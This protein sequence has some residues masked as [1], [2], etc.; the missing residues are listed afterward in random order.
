MPKE[1][2]IISKLFDIL[3][4]DFKLYLP[5]SLENSHFVPTFIDLLPLFSL[6]FKHGVAQSRIHQPHLWLL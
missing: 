1:R 5:V 2:Y 6:L 4:I 3:L